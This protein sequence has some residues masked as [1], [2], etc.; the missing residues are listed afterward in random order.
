MQAGKLQRRSTIIVR[1]YQN[2][3]LLQVAGVHRYA[4]EIKRCEISE[5]ELPN[6]ICAVL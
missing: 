5:R 2:V 3:L 4:L 6:W 1:A